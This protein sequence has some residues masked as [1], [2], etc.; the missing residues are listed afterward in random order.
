MATHARSLAGEYFP[1]APSVANRDRSGVGVP[2]G[3]YVS[4][5]PRQLGVLKLV[6][7]H[8]RAWNSRSNEARQIFVGRR[9]PE[10]PASQI[11]VRDC[12]AV[13]AVAERAMGA[14]QARSPLNIRLT[15]LTNVVLCSGRHAP[16]HHGALEKNRASKHVYKFY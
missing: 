14:V 2:H 15:V 1:A 13:G 12:V 6:R 7:R 4:Y 3:A 10:L 5:N 8:G 11:D 9:L 16:E